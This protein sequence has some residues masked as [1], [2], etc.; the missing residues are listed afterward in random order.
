MTL[1]QINRVD[2]Y[3][4]SHLHIISLC[5][6]RHAEPKESVQL[7]FTLDIVKSAQTRCT[8]EDLVRLIDWLRSDE[9]C[10]LLTNGPKAHC[11]AELIPSLRG[12]GVQQR[13]HT[14]WW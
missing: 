10:N 1:D 11:H 8:G 4:P 5:C 3:V 14:E 6:V 7:T 12:P 13:R 2:P 9:E